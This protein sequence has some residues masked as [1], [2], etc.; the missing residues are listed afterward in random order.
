MDVNMKSDREK[1]SLIA[2]VRAYALDNYNVDGWDYIVESYSDDEIAK[3]I[4][5]T[6]SPTVAIMRCRREL[7]TLDSVR[8]DIQGA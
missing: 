6:D 7:R 3:L 4:G 5:D 2:H 8:K 1:Q